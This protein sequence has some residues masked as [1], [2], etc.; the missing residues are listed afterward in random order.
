M[1]IFPTKSKSKAGK[2]RE[3]KPMHCIFIFFL[4]VERTIGK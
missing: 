2:E 1:Q 3:K 4:Q